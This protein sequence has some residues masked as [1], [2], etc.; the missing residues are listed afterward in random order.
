MF[1][2]SRTALILRRHENHA[3]GLGLLVTHKGGDFG[4]ISV[5]ER[6]QVSLFGANES[7]FLLKGS[8]FSTAQDDRVMGS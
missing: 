5:K 4:A 1:T 8:Y 6:M 2:L 7:K 3:P